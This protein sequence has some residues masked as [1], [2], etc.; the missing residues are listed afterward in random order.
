LLLCALI[1]L[2]VRNQ[3][4]DQGSEMSEHTQ[5]GNAEPSART[6]LQPSGPAPTSRMQLTAHCS[7]G[8]L[9][10]MWEAAKKSIQEAE[11]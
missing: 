5:L 2:V 8:F 9:G 10:T 6:Q 4:A 1:W 3:R 7:A 11:D